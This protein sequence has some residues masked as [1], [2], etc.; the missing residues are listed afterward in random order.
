MPASVCATIFKL[1]WAFEHEP[2]LRGAERCFDEQGSSFDF[3]FRRGP[4]IDVVFLSVM[5][6]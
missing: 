5:F 2:G 1:G 4:I 3:L 6:V